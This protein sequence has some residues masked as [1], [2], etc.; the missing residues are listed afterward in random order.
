M[1][2]YLF[3]LNYY[4]VSLRDFKGSHCATIVCLIFTVVEFKFYLKGTNIKGI[5][6]DYDNKNGDVEASWILL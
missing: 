2:S 3:E 4:R 6:E 5:E 1:D